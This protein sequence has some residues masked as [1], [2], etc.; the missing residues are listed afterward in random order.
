MKGLLGIIKKN[1]GIG[2]NN[3]SKLVKNNL[4]KSRDWWE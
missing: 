3:W 1:Q 4:K 2:G